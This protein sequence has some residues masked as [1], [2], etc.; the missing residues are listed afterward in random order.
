MNIFRIFISTKICFKMHHL[1]KITVSMHPN[2]S[3]H[4]THPEPQKLGPPLANPA[5]AHTLNNI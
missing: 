1:K 5:Y 3:R 4:E 2:P